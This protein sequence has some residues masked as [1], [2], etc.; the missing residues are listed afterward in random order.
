MLIFFLRTSRMSKSL[1]LVAASTTGLSQGFSGS[2]NV[3]MMLAKVSLACPSRVA[4]A[5]LALGLR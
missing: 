2:L 1:A 4:N 5:A 3:P